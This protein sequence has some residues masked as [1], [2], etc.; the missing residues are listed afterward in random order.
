MPSSVEESPLNKDL[1]NYIQKVLTIG[2]N[3]KNIR[4][5]LLQNGRSNQNIQPIFDYLKLGNSH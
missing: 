4:V 5:T 1:L 2:D 3:A